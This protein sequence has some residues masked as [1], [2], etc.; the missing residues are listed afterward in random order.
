MSVLRR[1]APDYNDLSTAR[2]VG[3]SRARFPGRKSFS[4]VVLAHIF[5]EP[6]C[7][8]VSRSNAENHFRERR[9]EMKRKGM[10]IMLAFILTVTAAPLLWAN[11]QM[12]RGRNEDPLM[13]LVRLRALGAELDLSASQTAQL[14]EIGRTVRE[15]NAEYRSAMKDRTAEAGLM[16]LADPSNIKGAEAILDRND[17]DKRGLRENVLEGIAKAIE[18]LTPEQR[19]ILERKISGRDNF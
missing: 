8:D 16:L 11:H 10:S 6:V 14:R 12:Q 7:P 17:A 13:V 3:V 9:Q 5:N 19:E 18:I 4:P 15:A 1:I 2:L